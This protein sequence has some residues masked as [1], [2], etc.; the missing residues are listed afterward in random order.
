VRVTECLHNPLQDR[1]DTLHHLMIPKAQYA[2]ALLYQKGSASSV[3]FHLRG[4]LTAI[5]LYNQATF[6]AAEVGNEA[7]N[8]MLSTE[9]CAV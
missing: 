4:V 8:R 7:T 6:R 1:L 2:I 9:F 3:R 5:Q